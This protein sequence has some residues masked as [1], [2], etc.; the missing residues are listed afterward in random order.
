MDKK[1][2]KRVDEKKGLTNILIGVIVL[3]VIFIAY[4]GITVM[5]TGNKLGKI[6][7][8]IEKINETPEETP[9]KTTGLDKS[10]SL[11]TRNVEYRNE[12]TTSVNDNIGLTVNVSTDKKNAVL[13][14]D[15]P[16][17]SAAISKEV[18]ATYPTTKATYNILGFNKTIKNVLLTQYDNTLSSLTIVYLMEDNTVQYTTLVKSNN[19]VK[20]VDIRTQEGTNNKYFATDGTV[21]RVTD[22][23]KLYNVDAYK[24]NEKHKTS[25]ALKS[26]GKFYDL[27]YAISEIN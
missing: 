20:Y 1:R 4:L 8:E 15:W 16:T 2:K 27:G 21:P 9:S 24:E 3:L 13:T 5:I 6:D 11:N 25:I 26:D 23:Y 18:P 12:R 14:I 10:N 22:V 19:G 17:F 7:D